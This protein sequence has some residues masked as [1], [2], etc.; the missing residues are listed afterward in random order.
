MI[1]VTLPPN[2]IATPPEVLDMIKCGSTTDP[3]TLFDINVWMLRCEVVALREN[4]VN[5]PESYD[6]FSAKSYIPG[7]I[8]YA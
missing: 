6:S 3:Y 2:V 8:S 7:G 5:R 1:P 4:F